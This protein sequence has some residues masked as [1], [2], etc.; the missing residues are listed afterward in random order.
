[1]K[2]GGQPSEERIH[3]G[4][5]RGEAVPAQTTQFICEATPHL[6]PLPR[7][8]RRRSAFLSPLLCKGSRV[9]ETPL[10]F[11][12]KGQ[13]EG[14]FSLLPRQSNRVCRT[15]SR[16]AAGKWRLAPLFLRNEA[17]FQR[18]LCLLN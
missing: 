18:C 14:S 7:G 5:Q 3:R 15:T 10:S 2:H 17:N 6:N 16:A 4:E 9:R 13:G 8:E 1:M 11:A 12:A